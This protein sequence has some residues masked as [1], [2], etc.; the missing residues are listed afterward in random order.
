[1]QLTQFD[2]IAGPLLIVSALI[3]LARGGTR[4]LFTV[5]AFLGAAAAALFTLRFTAP[6]AR[7][8]V[9]PDWAGI[10]L[11]LF[12]VGLLTYIALRL[13]GAGMTRRVQETQ[14]LGV[15]DRVIGGGFGL[16]RAFVLLGAFN[17][18]FHMATPP[19][20]A[21][22]WVTG[23]LTY[24]VTEAGGRLLKAFAPEGLAM[25]KSVAPAIENAVKA[26]TTAPREAETGYDRD[27]RE[28]MDDLVEKAR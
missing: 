19:D 26:G 15:A 9:D 25:A 14:A 28:A 24:P 18:L 27:E 7:K 6:F 22:K 1:M 21:P 13:L 17:L 3:G 5:L 4:E 23:A 11:A 12:F 10:G 20:R 2:F 8:L 16:V